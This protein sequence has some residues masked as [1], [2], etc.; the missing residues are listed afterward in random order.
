MREGIRHR[1]RQGRHATCGVSGVPSRPPPTRSGRWCSTSCRPSSVSSRSTRM[2]RHLATM[3]GPLR[4]NTVPADLLL[5]SRPFPP[6]VDLSV[7]SLTPSRRR[8]LH[9][10]SGGLVPCRV[11]ESWGAVHTSGLV[12]PECLPYTGPETETRCFPFTKRGL[13][14]GGCGLETTVWVDVCRSHKTVRQCHVNWCDRVSCH[15]RGDSDTEVRPPTRDI[16]CVLLRI[17]GTVEKHLRNSLNEFQG[18]ESLV[19]RP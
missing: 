12:L 10:R 9:E 5:P 13:V 4:P 3:G 6:E 18:G 8:L 17:R 2:S 11:F 15:D 1:P 7:Q 14:V 19:S 16:K